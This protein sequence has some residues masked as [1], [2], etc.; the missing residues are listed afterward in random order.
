MK[1]RMLG[2][3]LVLVVAGVLALRAT[4]HPRGPKNWAL[5]QSRLATIRIAGDTVRV[6]DVRSFVYGDSGA[7]TPRWVDRTY[8]LDRLERVWFAVSPFASWRGPAH[9]FLSFQFSDSTFVS[10]SVEA[11]RQ[12][13]EKYSP[14]QG[15]LRQ[16]RLMVVI[17]EERDVIGLRANVW[18]DPVYLYP[19]RAT[20]A[21]ARAL[22]LA[23][24]QRER[25]LVDEPEY[26]NTLTN[27]CA[28]NLAWAVNRVAPKRARWSPALILPGYADDYA[29]D[30]DLLDVAEPLDSVRERYRI[31]ERA[32]AAWGM[33]GYSFAI[34]GR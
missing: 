24:L 19:G 14:L 16:Y 30:R 18:N 5:D 17:G 32:H 10:V 8:R 11:R 12:V 9:T 6:R 26:Y 20:A 3:M 4:A 27:N 7:V 25:G 34:R 28:T 21:Q 29:E 23:L 2:A 1:R 22:L 31:N 13:G 33:P 15:A